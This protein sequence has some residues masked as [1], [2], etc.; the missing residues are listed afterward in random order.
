MN[1][2]VL[3]R[4]TAVAIGGMALAGIVAVGQ[5]A[6]ADAGGTAAT[7]AGSGAPSPAPVAGASSA[8]STHGDR[9]TPGV[10][11]KHL[12]GTCNVY[13]NGDGD[14]CLWYLR[15][16]VGSRADFFWADS[17]LNDNRFITPGAGQGQIVGNN[18][19]SAWNYD[20][21]LTAQ[22]WTGINNTGTAGIISPNSGGNFVVPFINNVESFRW[23]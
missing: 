4:G 22:V 16:F 2:T 1:R 11:A 6:S 13:S 20:R 23:I 12:D 19:E 21:H 5:P 14:L 18:S 10:S 9:N 7:S 15:N 8:S 17:N 3:R